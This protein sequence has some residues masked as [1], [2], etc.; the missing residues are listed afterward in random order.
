ML[1]GR[2][3]F[4]LEILYREIKSVLL[5]IKLIHELVTLSQEILHQKLLFVGHSMFT[6]QGHLNTRDLPLGPFKLRS[7]VSSLM[8]KL[9]DDRQLRMNVKFAVFTVRVRQ[10]PFLLQVL[11]SLHSPNTLAIILLDLAFERLVLLSDLVKVAEERFL[12]LR[13]GV[14][15]QLVDITL[16][17]HRL[18]CDFAEQLLHP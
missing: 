3:H 5:M 18:V 14:A 8:L 13:G 15:F 16:E 4:S 1:F 12:V 10:C 6:H 11:E 2:N 7:I 17:H 9:L